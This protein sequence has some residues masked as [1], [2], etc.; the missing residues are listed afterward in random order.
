MIFNLHEEHFATA[1]AQEPTRDE[2]PISC[3][4]KSVDEL[5]R[6]VWHLIGAEN[7]FRGAPFS[8]VPEHVWGI[9]FSDL[10]LGGSLDEQSATVLKHLVCPSSQSYVHV[11]QLPLSRG[12]VVRGL[13]RTL[14]NPP[15]N[16]LQRRFVGENQTDLLSKDNIFDAAVIAAGHNRPHPLP[17][18]FSVFVFRNRDSTPA[19]ALF[20]KYIQDLRSVISPLVCCAPDVMAR[21]QHHSGRSGDCGELR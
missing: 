1:A 4:C 19:V 10:T 2:S 9:L 16:S 13:S 8:D 12:E 11:Q 6:Y 20:K 21:L 3:R 18:H 15:F 14:P 17:G 7:I 5:S